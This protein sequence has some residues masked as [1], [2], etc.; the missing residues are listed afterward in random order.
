MSNATDAKIWQGMSMSNLPPSLPAQPAPGPSNVNE[1]HS[2]A[3]RADGSRS[4]EAG[5]L[6]IVL[7]HLFGERDDAIIW[8]LEP[9][10]PPFDQVR[11]VRIDAAHVLE[12]PGEPSDP[13]RSFIIIDDAHRFATLSDASPIASLLSKSPRVVLIACEAT[14]GQADGA[15][16]SNSASASLIDLGRRAALEYLGPVHV[17][18]S[19]QL[20]EILAQIKTSGRPALLHLKCRKAILSAPL[21][22]PPTAAPPE[23]QPDRTGRAT[24][25]QVAS[26]ALAELARTD[27]RI[28][29]AMELDSDFSQDWRD[30]PNRVLDARSAAA[31]ALQWSAALAGEGG[32]PFVFMT[33]QDLQDSFGRFRQEVCVPRVPVT[34]LV[35]PGRRE[36]DPWVASSA[37]LAGIRQLSPLCVLS[38]KDGV[39]LTQMIHWCSAHEGPCVIWLPEIDQPVIRWEPGSDIAA[40][41]AEQLSAGNQV[42]II[43][44]GPMATAAQLAAQWMRSDGIETTVINA[45]FAQPLDR[46]TIA[47]AARNALCTVLL[48]GDDAS[49]GFTSWVLDELSRVGV[50]QPVAIVAPPQGTSRHD[51]HQ[52]HQQC[53]MRIVEHCR[54]LIE[55]VGR[56]WHA[57]IAADL[58]ATTAGAPLANVWLTPPSVAVRRWHDDQHQVLAQQFSPF[59]EG[60]VREYAKVGQRDIYLWRWCLHG[61]N[62]TTLPC[63]APELRAHVCDTKLLSIIL[64]VLLDD[65]ADQHGDGRLLGSLLE[66]AC[67]GACPSWK[68][69]SAA[70]RNLG[71][72]AKAVWET[73][74]SRIVAYPV[75]STFEPV[76]RYDLSQ[77]FNT[78]R[79]SHLVNGRPYLLNMAEHDSYTPHNMMMVSF[80][81]LDLMCSPGFPQQDVGSLREAIW[82][83]QCMGRIG[84]LLSTWRRELADRDFTSGV[85]ARAIVAGDLTLDELEHGDAATLEAAV[86]HNDHEA[87]FYRQWMEHRQRCHALAKRVRSIDLESVLEG[88]DR[89]FAMHLGS[90]GLI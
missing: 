25:R 63:V 9:S 23:V 79:Y 87:Y 60:W 22:G 5:G 41:Q 39:E 26:A 40:G 74:W 18:D 28:M 43:A 27:E 42:A 82:H 58:P 12:H 52:A 59:I 21:E 55:P 65:V 29:V 75:R 49:G 32:R 73:Y 14:E 76:L 35:E 16:N 64:C 15:D 11:P 3:T 86:R 84:N 1:T 88:H 66:M 57:P 8:G 34:L 68:H 56:A 31:D 47:Q 77:F 48:D 53:A 50:T 44:W 19:R 45:R 71:E 7:Q 81:T 51:R 80:S 38:P 13:A 85:F 72:I 30:L 67:C 70:E 62:L 20:L 54:W 10:A 90:Q 83:A 78:M 61:L 24:F 37:A 89:F 69:L 2:R 33:I 36:G 4:A 17:G 46:D 6:S